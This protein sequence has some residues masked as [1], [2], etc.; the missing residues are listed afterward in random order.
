VAPVK[1]VPVMV[2]ICPVFPDVGVKE[3]IAGAGITVT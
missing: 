2:T 1:F 3:L